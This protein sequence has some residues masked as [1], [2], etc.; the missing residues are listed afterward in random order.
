MKILTLDVETTISN[1]GNPFDSTNKLVQVGLKSG[2][3]KT[4]VFNIEYTEEP[5]KDKL[6]EIQEII[7][8]HDYL[9]G[10]NIKF[11]LNWLARYGIHFRTKKIWDTQLTDFMLDGQ[12]NPY[13]SLNRTCEKY[14][15]EQKLDVV[16]EEYWSNGIDTTEVPEDILTEYLVKD[17]DLT[18][19]VFMK[20]LGELKDNPQLKKLVALH[21]ADLLGLHEIETNGLLFNQKWSMELADGL[22]KEIK[23]LDG[24]LGD[25]HDFPSFNVGSNDHVSA[26]LYG[27]ILPYRVQEEDGHYK[28][29][30][31]KGQV[32]FKWVNKE[33]TFER[34]V[35]PIKKSE[36]A[37]EG[38][39][40]VNESTIRQLK[41]RKKAKEVIEILL[42]RSELAKRFGTYYQGLPKLN[43]E[44]YWKYGF[45]HGN[46]NQCVAS[47]GRLSSSKPNIQNFDGEI[48][49][50]FVTRY[51]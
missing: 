15:F 45:L 33:H 35:A 8:E 47:T 32:K 17:V 40:K 25:Y 48:K 12:A 20:Q 14:G 51:D 31:K 49:S 39:F 38:F 27:G 13:P 2:R 4:Q 9:V 16:K 50:L 28:T 34:L 37:K 46:L 3:D 26:L 44:M 7:D 30:A 21:N 11:D 18:F 1:K 10:F 29:G 24:L 42:K 6:E 43:K 36:R 23:K 22:E 41:G 19:Q 5:Y